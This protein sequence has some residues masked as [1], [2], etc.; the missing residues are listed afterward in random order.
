MAEISGFGL[1]LFRVSLRLT[2]WLNPDK[3]LEIIQQE[4]ML[5]AV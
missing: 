4:T 2:V 1:C 5:E 3:D